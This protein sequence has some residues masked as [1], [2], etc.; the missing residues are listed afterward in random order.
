MRKIVCAVIVLIATTIGVGGSADAGGWAVVTLDPLGEAPIVG[1]PVSVGFTI[2]QHGVTPY[3]T[4]NASIVVSD[5]TG[6][7]ERFVATPQGQAGHHVALVTFPRRGTYRWE[8]IPD[9]FPK[10]SLGSI[11][12]APSVT[13]SATVTTTTTTVREPIALT[14]RV[15]LALTLAIALVL[16]ALEVTTIRRRVAT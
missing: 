14:L 13:P 4:A 2:L 16:A 5:E 3:T 11:D 9:W 10:Q 1:Q 6:K 7:T 12:V 8:V 15:S